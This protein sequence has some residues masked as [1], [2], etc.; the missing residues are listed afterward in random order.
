MFN[1]RLRYFNSALSISFDGII[2]SK[3]VIDELNVQ[4]LNFTV[5]LLHSLR[6]NLILKCSLQIYLVFVEIFLFVLMVLNFISWI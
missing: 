3:N 2:K 1:P 6:R 5:T 4:K